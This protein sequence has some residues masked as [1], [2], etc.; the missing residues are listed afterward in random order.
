MLKTQNCGELRSAHA[1][2]EVTLA[3]W[4][5]RRR[6]Q[7]GLIFIDLRDRWG[8]TQVRIDQE[9]QPEAH[10]VASGLRGEYVIQVRGTVHLRPAG[11]ANPKIET[12]EIE[13]IPTAIQVL[14][15]AKTPPFLISG[16]DSIA[17]SEEARMKYRYLDLRRPSM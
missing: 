14:N 1:G 16:D 5:H 8:I 6:D 2:Q 9:N 10:A 11:T 7:G 4:V 3:G 12:G 13:V 15:E 17:I